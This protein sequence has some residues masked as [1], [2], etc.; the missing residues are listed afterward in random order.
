MLVNRMKQ[1]VE[2]AKRVNAR[3][4]T[5]VPGTYETGLEWDYQTAN[6]IENLKHCAAV[7]EAYRYCDDF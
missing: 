2:I 7:I 1:A 4:C 6:C 3:W 5:V